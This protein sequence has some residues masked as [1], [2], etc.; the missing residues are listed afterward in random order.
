MFA[1]TSPYAF[2]LS[3]EKWRQCLRQWQNPN[4]FLEQLQ[5]RNCASVSKESKSRKRKRKG[6]GPQTG[7]LTVCCSRSKYFSG[8]HRYR[9]STELSLEQVLLKYKNS[10]EGVPSKANTDSSCSQWNS[11]LSQCCTDE[12]PQYIR[13]SIP[14]CPS[15]VPEGLNDKPQINLWMTLSSQC[16]HS[17]W[18]YDSNNNYLCVVSGRKTIHLLPPSESERLK[19]FPEGSLSSN[20]TTLK[21]KQGQK[22]RGTII[23][24]ASSGTGVFIPEGWWHRVTSRPGTVA[25]NYWYEGI[26]KLLWNKNMTSYYFRTMIDYLVSLEVDRRFEKVSKTPEKYVQGPLL[27]FISG[28]TTLEDLIVLASTHKSKWR[29]S[30]LELTPTGTALL[31]KKLDS[32]K[33]TEVEAVVADELSKNII[34]EKLE[35][36]SNDCRLKVI[37]SMGVLTRNIA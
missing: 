19:P 25:I 12:L 34:R 27:S 22:I 8:S 7:L 36:F 23:L 1:P 37:E 24:R 20:H 10:V 28:N 21:P 33:S 5:K 4:F 31:K 17:T 18:H 32:Y 16:T 13:K 29:N 26:R 14:K 2:Q 15:V 30:I 35:A 3:E 11:Y 9:V 6:N